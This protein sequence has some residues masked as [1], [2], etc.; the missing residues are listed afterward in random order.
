MGNSS[1]ILQH[2]YSLDA[3]SLDFSRYLH[4]LIRYDEEE[5]YLTNLKEPELARLLGFLDKVRVVLL[6]FCQFRD[7]PLQALNI[8]PTNDVVVP[9]CLEKLQAICVDRETLPPSYI[10]SGE[11][12]RVGNRP[13]A[14]NAEV[15]LWEGTYR[16]KKVYIYSSQIPTGGRRDIMKVRIL[17]R[18]SSSHMLMDIL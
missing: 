1:R 14:A 12:A 18:V 10:I 13:I 17:S 4:C 11:L 2:L 9:E 7:G 15:D 16:G 6:S 3:S 8:V 5:R